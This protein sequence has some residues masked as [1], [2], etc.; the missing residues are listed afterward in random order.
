MPLFSKPV[1]FHTGHLAGTD[2]VE[3]E[4]KTSHHLLSEQAGI[5]VSLVP[6]A[7]SFLQSSPLVYDSSTGT[8]PLQRFAHHSQ[9]ELG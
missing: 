1:A 6:A 9:Q 5:P 7:S 4:L 8:E 2:K 3:N